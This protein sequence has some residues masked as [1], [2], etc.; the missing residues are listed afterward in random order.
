MIY[1]LFLDDVREIRQVYART[2]T[3]EWFLAKNYAEFVKCISNH[4]LPIFISF[5]HDLAHEHYRQSMYDSDKHYNEYYTDGT[6]KEKTGYDC[7]KWLV[8]Y[9]LDN[10]LDLPKWACHSMNPIGKQNIE[11]VLQNYETHRSNHS[12][13]SSEA[14]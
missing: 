4:G 14:K 1:K 6:F 11:S 12:E 10:N 13:G 8:E 5:D 3:Q 7:A 2:N 9:C